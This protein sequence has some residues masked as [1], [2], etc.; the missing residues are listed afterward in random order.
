MAGSP[1]S[2][3]AAL[4]LE[5]AI[6]N[7]CIHKH[8]LTNQLPDVRESCVY[9]YQPINGYITAPDLPGIGQDVKN[10]TLEEKCVKYQKEEFGDRLKRS[11]GAHEAKS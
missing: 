6:P 1:I 4:Q 10:E 3:A 5:T 8:H 2:L 11:S 7:F 9:D